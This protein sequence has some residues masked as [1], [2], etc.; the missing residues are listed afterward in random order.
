LCI[1]THQVGMA[2]H[3]CCIEIDVKGPHRQDC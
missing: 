3:G 2:V 1:N